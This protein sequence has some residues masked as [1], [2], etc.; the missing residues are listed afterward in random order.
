MQFKLV[1]L[2]L[3]A[4]F[5]RLRVGIKLMLMAVEPMLMAVEPKLIASRAE[6]GGK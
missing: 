3:S 5:I 6:S 2:L 1:N 4:A